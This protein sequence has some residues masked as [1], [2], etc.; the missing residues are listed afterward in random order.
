MFVD[1][2]YLFALVGAAACAL[3]ALVEAQNAEPHPGQAP[4]DRVCKVCHGPEGKGN[5][6]PRL[7]PFTMD[8]DEL[9]SRVRE[10]GGEMPPISQ[11]RVSDEEVK[12]IAGYLTALGAANESA[13][14]MGSLLRVGPEKASK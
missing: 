3:A 13:A 7:V 9:M 8:V 14:A 4:Y 2:R 10:G 11:N 5:A 1:T 6:A 12:Q